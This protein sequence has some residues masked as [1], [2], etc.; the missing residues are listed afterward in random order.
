M[1]SFDARGPKRV[2]IMYDA[3]DGTQFESPPD[4]ACNMQAGL[5][6]MAGSG[7]VIEFSDP[8]F[9]AFQRGAEIKR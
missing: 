8:L 2:A 1:A 4:V 3:V 7:A 6:G 5:E 9:E